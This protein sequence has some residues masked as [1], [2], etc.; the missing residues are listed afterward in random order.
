MRKPT[1]SIDGFVLRPGRRDLGRAEES[2]IVGT[3]ESSRPLISDSNRTVYSTGEKVQ[4]K[5]EP[6]R[7]ISRVDVDESLKTIDDEVKQ[8]HRKRRIFAAR[9]T[10]GVHPSRRKW[11]KR[12]IILI[13]LILVGIAAY[14][15]IRGFIASSSIFK[16]NLFGVFT[17][18]PLKMDANG[19]TNILVFGTS[20]SIDDQRHEGANLTDTLMVLSVD[21]NK[22]NAYMVS[23]PRDLYIK[24]DQTCSAGERGKINGMYICY[25][26]DDENEENAAAAL[27]TKVSEVTG[28]DIQYYAHINWAVVVGSV[29]AVGGV[30]VDVKGNGSCRFLG[31][32]DGS[33]VDANMKIKY[34]PGVH[35]MDGLAALTF[36]RARGEAAPNCGLDQGDF[37]RQA[38]QQKVLKALQ[39]KALSAGTLTNLGKVTSLIDTLGQNL[40]TNFDTSE[41]QTLMS[42]GKDIPSDKITSISLVDQD[43]PQIVTGSAAIGAGSIQVPA[44]GTFDYSGIHDYINK[45][46]NANDVTREDAHIAVYNGSG[47]VGYAQRR[48]DAL[49]KLGFKITDVG[50]APEG[51]YSDIEIFDLTGKKP[52][53]KAKLE[54]IYG[55]SAKPA[56]GSPMNVSVDTD[57]VIIYGKALTDN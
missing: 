13:I 12:I 44:E 29:N 48:S 52:A 49:E 20:G 18:K 34:T 27:D 36:S 11:I 1:N 2:T 21:Q 45:Q 38:N 53:T 8:P 16:G 3:G 22:K 28:L 7:R 19:R 23:L 10:K 4:P 15:G 37:D 56:S 54:S 9:K 14:V 40:R 57:F 41:I 43:D 55:V 26:E 24:Y 6:Q 5:G 17:S 33:V 47:T 35:T 25:T 30:D 32:P 31:M 46:L 39:Q 51:S 42:L 50:N